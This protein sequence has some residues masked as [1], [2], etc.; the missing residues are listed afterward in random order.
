M[1]KRGR[2]AKF[3][4]HQKESIARLVKKY[5]V[6]KTQEILAAANGTELAKLRS[7]SRFPEPMEVCQP[8]IAKAAK[9][10]GVELHRGR[11]KVEKTEGQPDVKVAE[12]A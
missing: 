4:A 11:P 3:N 12:A 2:P 9:E 10:C 5:N 8:T 7:V 1:K 6:G